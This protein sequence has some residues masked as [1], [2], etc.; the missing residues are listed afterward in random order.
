MISWTALKFTGSQQAHSSEVRSYQIF[1]CFYFL[2]FLALVKSMNVSVFD[3]P[4]QFCG[5]NESQGMSED[6]L[7]EWLYFLQDNS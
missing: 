5:T 3:F 7:S 4:H 6:K 2:R 1:A